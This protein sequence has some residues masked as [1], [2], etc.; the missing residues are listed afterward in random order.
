MSKKNL[1]GQNIN[2]MMAIPNHDDFNRELFVQDFLWKL[3]S[4]YLK[5]FEN[6]FPDSNDILSDFDRK[7]VAKQR[8]Q[9]LNINS[10]QFW[11]SLKRIGREWTC[12]AVGPTVQKQ[13]PS[14]IKKSQ[15]YL[16]NKYKLGTLILDKNL[17]IP[18]YVNV[19][20]HLKPGGYFS[21]LCDNDIFAGAE[22]ERTTYINVNGFFGPKMDFLG[23]SVANWYKKKYPFKKPLKILEVGCAIGQSTTAWVESFPQASVYAIDLSSP[24][25]RYA[26]SRAEAEGV[27]I[28]F[29]QQNAEK[30]NFSNNYFDLVV[31]HAT[32]HETSY[33]AIQN[34][35]KECYRILN[36]GGLMIHN[37]G[38]PFRD[39]KPID[40]I[41]PDWDTHFN[42]EPFIS[43]M[44]SIDLAKLANLCDWPTGST[45]NSY[46]NDLIKDKKNNI[47]NNNINAHYILVGEK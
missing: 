17:K 27:K 37:E 33:K 41:I 10:G 4:E 20:I 8:K 23:L 38:K 26:H 3:N 32:L 1:G 12:E 11:S 30:T 45:F 22:Y 31:S 47:T 28:H 21:E 18:S 14:L 13:L 25:L 5:K 42:A 39:L 16:N 2:L 9:L 29:S 40:R 15:T 46:A 34:I 35:F 36:K 19:D 6:I 24:M 43:K 44:R 7:S